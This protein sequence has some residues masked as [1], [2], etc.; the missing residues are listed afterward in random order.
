MILPNI[1]KQQTRIL[2]FLYKFR[3]LHTKQ[4]QILLSHQNPQR[5]Q[6]WLKKLRESGFIRL[7]K[8][9]KT[10]KDHATPDVYQLGLKARHI[11][12][13]DPE[14][15]MKILHKIYKKENLSETFIE[16]SLAIADLYLFFQLQL[17]ENEELTFFTESELSNYSYFPKTEPGAGAYITLTKDADTRN[18]FLEYFAKE[19]TPGELRYRFKKYLKYFDSGEWQEHTKEASIPTLLFVFAL[20]RRKNYIRLYARSVLDK[21]IDENIELFVTTKEKI[22]PGNTSIW[23]KV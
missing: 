3:Y 23:E 12:K 16:R 6:D 21:K 19:I 10:Y 22:H 7:Y 9:P 4:I 15:D 17:G 13:N 11:L 20:S 18:Y 8:E 14:C 1:T 5:T 2:Y